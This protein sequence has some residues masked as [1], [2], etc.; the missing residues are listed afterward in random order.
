MR[1]LLI[2]AAVAGASWFDEPDAIEP[3][4]DP[5]SRNVLSID[6]AAINAAGRIRAKII[7]TVASPTSFACPAC[8]G[9]E[10]KARVEGWHDG[11]ADIDLR[12]IKQDVPG[13]TAYPWITAEG[14]Q[15][16]YG[17]TGINGIRQWL[18]LPAVKVSAAVGAVTIGTIDGKALRDFQANIT[19]DG[20]YQ[21]GGA[22]LTVPKSMPNTVE[23]TPERQAVKFTG[24][25]PR[26][27]YGSG[28]LAVSQPVAGFVATRETLT[29]Q[30][31]GFPDLVLSV[32]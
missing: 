31:D 6:E 16:I 9:M 29:V 21:F 13:A 15:T 25:K 26:L 20:V 23:L 18:K 5:I 30:L 4:P 2:L 24:A 11:D 1:H 7:V 8:D 28:W 10:S 22:K 19:A 17:R 27:S 3:I 32:R 12:W 14:H